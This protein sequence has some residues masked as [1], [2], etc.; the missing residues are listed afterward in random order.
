MDLA[1]CRRGWFLLIGAIFGAL[2]GGGSLWLVG[3]LWKRLRGVDAMGLGDVKMLFGV[4][5]LLGWRLTILTIFIGAL[6]GAIGGILLMIGAKDKN[7]QTQIPFLEFFLESFDYCT[8][9]SGM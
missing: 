4:G 6:T 3:E 9:F 7:M 5:A 1:K 2:A 8:L